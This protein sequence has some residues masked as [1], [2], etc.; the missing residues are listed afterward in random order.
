M[1]KLKLSYS[2]DGAIANILLDDGKGNVLV[3]QAVAGD[4]AAS[5]KLYPAW[6]ESKK[7]EEERLKDVKQLYQDYSGM[8]KLREEENPEY[9]KLSRLLKEQRVE[10]G[11]LS[12]LYDQQLKEDISQIIRRAQSY[13][14]S[15]FLSQHAHEFDYKVNIQRQRLPAWQEKFVW[16]DQITIYDVRKNDVVGYSKR[17]LGYRTLTDGFNLVDSNPFRGSARLGDFMA[18]RFDDKVLFKYAYRK[19]KGV[20]TGRTYNFNP[21]ID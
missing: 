7:K 11:R 9:L 6:Q 10:G 4:Y 3:Y 15:E 17:G 18:Y 12:K 20:G 13:R 2:H 16:F 21:A 1:E 19:G 5:K 8:V 14:L